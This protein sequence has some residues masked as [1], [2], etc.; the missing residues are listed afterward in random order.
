VYHLPPPFRLAL[1]P[2]TATIA[3]PIGGSS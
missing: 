2:F 1:L 3:K